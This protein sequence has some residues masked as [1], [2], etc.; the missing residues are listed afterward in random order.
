MTFVFSVFKFKYILLDLVCFLVSLLRN[1]NN[2]CIKE[3]N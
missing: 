3:K 1:N 2:H